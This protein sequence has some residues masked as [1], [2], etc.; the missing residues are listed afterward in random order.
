MRGRDLDT[1]RAQFGLGPFVCDQRD[2]AIDQRQ[3]QSAAGQGHV[4]ELFQLRQQGPAALADRVD[5]PLDVLPFF[6][7]R[8]GQLVQQSRLG[9]LQGGRRVRMHGHGRIA[10]HGLRPRGGDRHVR[11]F[12]WL[13]VDDRVL[14]VPEM[15]FDLLVKHLV[16][17]DRRL[18]ERVP[19]DQ[20]LAA[21]DQPLTE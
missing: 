21:I 15:P 8:F 4:A 10:Q 2:H 7:R 18:Q 16:V 1:A 19:V 12:T 5:L 20:P 11:R 14:E 6:G 13:R 3:P 9:A 17:T